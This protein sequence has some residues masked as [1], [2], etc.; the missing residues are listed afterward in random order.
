MD[1]ATPSRAERARRRLR[2]LASVTLALTLLVILWGA[3]VRATG[4][5]AGCGSH[6]PT[7]NGQVIPRN[8]STQTLI[9]YTH[10]VSS[11][12]AFLMVLAQAVLAWRAWPRRARVRRAAGLTLLFM[13][14]EALVGGGLVIFEMVAGNTQTARA[15]WMVAHLLNTFALLAAQVLTVWWSGADARPTRPEGRAP[16]WRAAILAGALATLLVAASGAVAALGD[17]LFPARSLAEGL[18]QDLAPGAHLFLRLR[19]LHPFLAAGAAL[20]LLVLLA[21]FVT[22]PADAGPGPARTLALLAAGLVIVQVAAGLLN[23]ILLAPV[24]LQLVHLLLADVLWMTLVLLTATVFWGS[25]GNGGDA[26]PTGEA[27]AA[28]RA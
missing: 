17:T 8:P 15:A 2:A 27:G 6:W 16:R 14:T 24:W 28:P 7:C 23:L 20:Y 26:P 5:G 9:E 19:V 22:A 1:T 4:S 10:R 11:G 13:V 25:M 12:V 21:L 3:F 18:A